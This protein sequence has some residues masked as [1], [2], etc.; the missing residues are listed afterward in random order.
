MVLVEGLFPRLALLA[1]QGVRESREWETG[2]VQSRVGGRVH[3]TVQEKR[4]QRER[5]R[6]RAGPFYPEGRGQCS[7]S[8]PYGGLTLIWQLV[9]F[10]LTKIT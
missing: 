3:P 6:Y 1:L 5:E 10:G 7:L 9:Q 4:A 8:V 2:P